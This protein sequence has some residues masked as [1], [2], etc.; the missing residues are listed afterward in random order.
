MSNKEKFAG[1][2]TKLVE[3][4]EL[5]YGAEIRAK[6]GDAAVEKSSAKVKAMT[7]EQ[8]KEVERLSEEFNIA[9]KQAFEAGDP[10]SAL[11]QKAC[12]LHKDWLCCFWDDYSKET[13]IGI[14]EM[15][16]SDP[17]F[18]AYYDKIA[19]GCAVFLRDALLVFCG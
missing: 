5:K 14:A 9:L 13:H 3:D 16:V 17:R 12:K 18:A 15:Y 1:F 19:P 2:A 8:Y 6:Y 10:T 4:N 7:E 11:A